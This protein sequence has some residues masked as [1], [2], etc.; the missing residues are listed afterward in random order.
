MATR[1]KSSDLPGKAPP[2]APTPSTPASPTTDT[3]APPASPV[4]ARRQQKREAAFIGKPRP[5]SIE[6]A[7]HVFPNRTGRAAL[8][9]PADDWSEVVALLRTKYPNLIASPNP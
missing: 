8:Y 9:F 1:W 2:A 4:E 3:T 7:G 6:L 5:P